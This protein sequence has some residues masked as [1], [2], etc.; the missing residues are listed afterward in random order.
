[1]PARPG[2]PSRTY[3]VRMEPGTVLDRHG[4]ERFEHWSAIVHGRRMRTGDYS[5]APRGSVHEP[6]PSDEGALLFIVETP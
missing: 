1:M 3:L 4:H 6:I 2:D 5:Y